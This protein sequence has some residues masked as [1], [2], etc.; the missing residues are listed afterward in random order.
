MKRRKI[1][2]ADVGWA[3]TDSIVSERRAAA[4]RLDLLFPREALLVGSNPQGHWFR[5]GWCRTVFLP[6]LQLR[7]VGE[8]RHREGH[9]VVS[10][11]SFPS[12][13]PYNFNERGEGSAA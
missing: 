5:I 9:V 10:G 1:A 4:R 8:R 13:R 3:G 7:D 11:G 12:P 2:L 6:P